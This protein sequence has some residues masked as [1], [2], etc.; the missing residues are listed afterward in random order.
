MP[1]TNNNKSSGENR[2]CMYENLFINRPSKVLA[3]DA[4]ILPKMQTWYIDFTTKSVPV[5]QVGQFIVVR[6]IS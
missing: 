5:E 4:T 2:L 1:L 3:H 6:G